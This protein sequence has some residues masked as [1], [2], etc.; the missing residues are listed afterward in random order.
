MEHGRTGTRYR[1]LLATH[2]Q[3]RLANIL[4]NLLVALI[5]G[6]M[7]L[8][9]AAAA[10]RSMREAASPAGVLRRLLRDP[11]EV[12][13]AAGRTWGPAT[14]RT[15]DAGP[16]CY[17]ERQ[18]YVSGK[19]GGWRTDSWIWTGADPMLELG[20][21]TFRLNLRALDF[22]PR[23]PEVVADETAYRARVRFE[24]GGRL[25]EQCL[26]D[27]ASA[28]A[29]LCVAP[30][31]H[32][33]DRCL[34]DSPTTLTLG[35]GSAAARVRR[36]AN[37][38]AAGLTAA[39]LAAALLAAYLWRALR[40]GAIV[41]ALGAWS[42]RP[43]PG[44]RALVWVGIGAAVALAGAAAIAVANAPSVIPHY[45]S[46]YVFAA[47]V[48]GAAAAGLVAAHDRRRKVMRAIEP[49][50]AA[51]TAR[52][53]RVG[54][55]MAELEVRVRAD[56]PTV[57][58]PGV[59]SFAFVRVEVK[60]V[61]VVGRSVTLVPLHTAAWPATVPVEDP[62]GLG[63]LDPRGATLDLRAHFFHASRAEACAF[64]KKLA[65]Q[66]PFG[67]TGAELDANVS[68]EVEVSYLDPGER[69]Y[70][71]GHIR[72]V[73]DPSVA[74]TYRAMGTLPVITATDD[75]K[76]AV[77]AGTEA[78]LLRGLAAERAY[79]T[80]AMGALAGLSGGLVAALAWLATR[81]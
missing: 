5:A 18:H 37:R 2:G 12:D 32:T 19:N 70:L 74:T 53:A 79:L 61:V 46:G 11:T 40:R 66:T 68:I 59:G 45:V 3:G 75:A 4:I 54:E 44:S 22:D 81:A 17:V 63:L 62:S 1:L 43:P 72:R 28:F 60:R 80:L 21:A 49:V 50:E 15:S 6:V 7:A 58:V 13:R 47:F 67:S 64:L 23:N 69:A 35:D 31:A 77:H 52:L 25:R 33:T 56:A 65:Q 57:E 10:V 76:L 24:A 55:G 20:R 36:H 73:E 8:V 38:A 14:L 78:S 42:R 27:G 30:G 16:L 41:E 48:L 51:E 29:D 26:H 9:C 71:L 34:D 39:L